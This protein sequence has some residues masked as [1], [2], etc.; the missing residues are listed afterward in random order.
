MTSKHDVNYAAEGDVSYTHIYPT[1]T[2]LN[3]SKTKYQSARPV[4]IMWWRGIDCELKIVAE[5]NELMK[6][7]L[8]SCII[9]IVMLLLF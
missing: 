1:Q 7:K 4:I 5:K 2:I 6:L 8:I 9:T 3:K